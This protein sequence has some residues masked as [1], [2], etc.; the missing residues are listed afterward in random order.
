MNKVFLIGNLTADPTSQTFDSGRTMCRFTIAVNRPTRNGSEA[1]AD[2]ISIVTWEN[3]AVNCAKFLAKGRKVAVVGSIQTGSYEKDGVKRYT[4][5]IRADQVEFLSRPDGDGASSGS[6][7]SRPSDTIDSLKEV[8][9]VD[10]DMP[11]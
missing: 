10:D 11:F 9:S 3:L 2:F 6:G 5:D 1:Q 8:D 4:T 7:Y